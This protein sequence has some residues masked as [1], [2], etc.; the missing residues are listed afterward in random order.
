MKV[1]VEDPGDCVAPPPALGWG[2]V[3]LHRVQGETS[4][5]ADVGV[6]AH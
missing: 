2:G 4:R 3:T 1:F 5:E 6:L